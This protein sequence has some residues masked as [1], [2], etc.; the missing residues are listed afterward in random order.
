MDGSYSYLGNQDFNGTD[1]LTYAVSDGQL[2]TNTATVN[3]TVTAV[4]DA[5]VVPSRSL[6]LNEDNTL[7]LDPLA[8]ATDAEG[9]PLSAS[10]I[11]G[12][13][14][15]SLSVNADGSYNHAY[16]VDTGWMDSSGWSAVLSSVVPT[17]NR[18]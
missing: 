11:A 2:V 17:P 5:P 8:G 3:L 1:S 4:N 10:L 18:D 9:D 6:S 13:L 16:P 15:G 12:P 7:V 14:H